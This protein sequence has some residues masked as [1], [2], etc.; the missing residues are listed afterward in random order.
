MGGDCPENVT[1]MEDL[2]LDQKTGGY[3][4]CMPEKGVLPVYVDGVVPEVLRKVDFVAD[5]CAKHSARVL[6]VLSVGGDS[7]CNGRPILTFRPFESGSG[8]EF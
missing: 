6:N 8:S 2:G 3:I 7:G 5:L 4:V 1:S